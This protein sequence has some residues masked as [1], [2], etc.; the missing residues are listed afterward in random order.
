MNTSAL[1]EAMTR[2]DN[3]GVVSELTRLGQNPTVV[4]IVSSRDD[5]ASGGPIC[6]W[7]VRRND[8]EH[9]LLDTFLVTRSCNGTIQQQIMTSKRIAASVDYRA[10]DTTFAAAMA[11]HT[12]KDQVAE[13][14]NAVSVASTIS[15]TI[16][17]VKREKAAGK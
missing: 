2:A 8:T 14:L 13:V 3:A 10:S 6:G 5:L 17:R 4:G 12:S 16:E 15:S 9:V 1:L 7:F 11:R